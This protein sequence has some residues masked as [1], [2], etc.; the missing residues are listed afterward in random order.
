MLLK[1]RILILCGLNKMTVRKLAIETGFSEQSFYRWFKEDSM[2]IKHLRKIAAYF[3]QDIS[4]FF[5]NEDQTYFPEAIVEEKSEVYESNFKDKYIQV[6][7]ANMELNNEI[8]DLKEK[9][10]D[11]KAELEA[12]KTKQP[13][14]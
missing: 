9:L 1:N 4:Y 7:E 11:C 2:E 6:L 10:E 8:K 12:M 14:T 13:V 5:N 3:K